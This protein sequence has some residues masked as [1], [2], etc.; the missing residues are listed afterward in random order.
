MAAVVYALVHAPLGSSA[1]AAVAFACGLAWGTLRDN[2]SSLVPSLV[3][4]LLWD[5]LVL[6]WLP[7]K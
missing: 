6:F 7:L 3:A 2:T 5:A 1:L 4:H